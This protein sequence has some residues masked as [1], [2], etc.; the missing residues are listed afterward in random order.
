LYR[1]ISDLKNIYQPITKIVKDEKGALF[2]DSH[3]ILARWL[4]DFSHLLNMHVPELS[5]FG[6]QLAVEKLKSHKSPGIDQTPAG[7]RTVCSDSHILIIAV[8][9]N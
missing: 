1:N 3:R 9:N 2:A 6:V 4:N 5:I 8:G 7:S